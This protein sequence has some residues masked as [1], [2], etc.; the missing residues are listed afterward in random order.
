MAENWEWEKMWSGVMV[1]ERDCECMRKWLR[2]R[3]R[4]TQWV[5][6]WVAW[7]HKEQHATVKYPSTWLLHTDGIVQFLDSLQSAQ[8]AASLTNPCLTANLAR[9]F[10]QI[11]YSVWQSSKVM[12]YQ[13]SSLQVPRSVRLKVSRSMLPWPLHTH[14]HTHAHLNPLKPSDY[15]MNHKV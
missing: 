1:W 6:Q 11:T 8:E 10:L 5:G 15:Y 7:L 12:P 13:I 2:L 4:V 9:R 14:T 3:R